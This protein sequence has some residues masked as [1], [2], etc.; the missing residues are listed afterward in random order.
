MSYKTAGVNELINKMTR[1]EILL[2]AMQRDYVWKEK[3][4][5]RL[6]DSLMKDYPIGAF[7]FWELNEDDI[8]GYEFNKFSC[9][10]DRL[11]N[12]DASEYK[13]PI[14]STPTAV[15]DG[16]QRLTSLYIGLYGWIRTKVPVARR[17][18][19]E[20][21][22]RYL[23][24]NLL[25]SVNN[26]KDDEYEFDFMS[27]SE[28]ETH[29]EG[30]CWFRVSDILKIKD[31]AKSVHKYV[32][33]L[34]L[35]DGV[36]PYFQAIEMLDKLYDLVNRDDILSYYPA[37]NKSLAEAVDIFERVNN[38][39]QT[40]S[41]TDLMLSMA[42][43]AQKKDMHKRIVEAIKQVENSTTF[44]TGFVPDRSFILT[45]AL[46]ASDAESVSTTYR[47]NY[48]TESIER[49]LKVWDSTID[50][51]CNAAIYLELLGFVGKKIGKSFVH[52]IA[53]YFFKLGDKADAKKWFNSNNAARVKDRDSIVQWLLRAN[54]K[55]LFD[56]G[57]PSQLKQIRDT[58]SKA[59]DGSAKNEF[60]L[61]ALLSANDGRLMDI[62]DD[63]V[64][65]V[66]KM[67]YNDPKL[68]PLLNVILVGSPFSHYHV[69][70][71]WPQAKMSTAAKIKKAAAGEELTPS[72]IEFY[73]GHYD[74][75]PNLQILPSSPNQAKG[76]DYFFEWL[77]S[78]FSSQEE[79]REYMN[80]CCIPEGIDYRYANFEEF[81]TKRED[82]LRERIKNYLGVKSRSAD[83]DAL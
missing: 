81:Y 55:G 29:N 20:H 39:G 49:I 69:D 71:C 25:H 59:M 26:L 3:Q 57:I 58:M 63:D 11:N 51:I 44:D 5:C 83:K 31:K 73:K 16:Q 9:E 64:E 1:G 47:D 75:L 80:H 14:G 21:P 77:E 42:S 24:L 12:P 10:I 66:L 70:H 13:V 53:Y 61:N 34:N 27:N 8:Q 40:L 18:N 41:G 67:K 30:Y 74:R 2:P 23:A 48:S 56:Y 43:A 4:V 79:R 46:M 76:S 72:Q 37:K 15:L 82:L 38:S 19:G 50:A 68:L 36:E 65:T 54:I 52:P 78:T 45:A 35:G 33:D 32:H 62:T 60:P 22:K 28:L 6:F 17:V 7:L